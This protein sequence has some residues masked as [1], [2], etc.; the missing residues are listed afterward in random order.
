AT[1]PPRPLPKVQATNPYNPNASRKSQRRV[2]LPPEYEDPIRYDDARPEIVAARAAFGRPLPAERIRDLQ[3][4]GRLPA[5]SRLP[6]SDSR[7]SLRLPRLRTAQLL[8]ARRPFARRSPPR[9]R[10]KVPTAPWL[11]TTTRPTPSTRQGPKTM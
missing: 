6:T 7:P 8:T 11:A 9:L 2:S 4:E 5:P 10:S 1:L 3:K